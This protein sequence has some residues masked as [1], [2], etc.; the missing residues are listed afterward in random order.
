MW[1]RVK[2]CKIDILHKWEKISFYLIWNFMLTREEKYNFLI[3]MKGWQENFELN[4]NQN[5]IVNLI[6]CYDG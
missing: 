6:K 3:K 4:I 1:F 5:I 2:L